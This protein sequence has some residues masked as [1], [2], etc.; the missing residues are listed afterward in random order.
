MII[1]IVAG[2]LKLFPKREGCSPVVAFLLQRLSGGI[3]HAVV[4]TGAVR[5]RHTAAILID[6]TWTHP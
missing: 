5:G 4:L 6:Q 2:E 1:N 3:K